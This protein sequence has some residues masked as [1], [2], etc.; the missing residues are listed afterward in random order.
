MS[1]RK[2]TS[3]RLAAVALLQLEGA[4]RAVDT[5][6]LAMKM[7]ALAPDRFRWK[8]YPEQINIEQVRM[9][10]SVLLRADP[11]FATGGVRYGWMLTAAGIA[12]A[13]QTP[14]MA[15]EPVHEALAQQA[16][17]LRQTDA[18][19][20]FSRVAPEEITV[21]DARRFLRVDEYTSV[22]R[23]KE[24]IQAVANIAAHDDG[25]H[26]LVTYLHEHFPEEWA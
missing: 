26:A 24:R 17:L 25:L 7:A 18:W 22:R 2:I 13:L 8:K 5:E 9:T 10:V 11:P 20:K 19:A 23:R 12:W 6:D 1:G 21:Y 14:G 16:A 3:Q 4:T 15:P